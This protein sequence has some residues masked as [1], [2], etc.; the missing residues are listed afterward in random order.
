MTSITVDPRV[1]LGALTVI[2]SHSVSESMEV[3]V[4]QRLH[5]DFTN[6]NETEIITIKKQLHNTIHGC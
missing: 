1:Y 4:A 3:N 2:R 5:T 6:A